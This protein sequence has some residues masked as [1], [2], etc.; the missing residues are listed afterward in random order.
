MAPDPSPMVGVKS[1]LVDSVIPVLFPAVTGPSLSPTTVTVT[2]VEAAIP[3]VAVVMTIAVADGAAEVPLTDPLINTLGVAEVLKKPGGY[4]KVIL[5]P[6]ASAPPTVVVK[7][8]V[9]DTFVLSATRSDSFI[10]NE[11]NDTRP[12]IPP[13]AVPADGIKSAL[14]DTTTPILL[15]PLA[16]PIVRPESVTVT[17]V[18]A[19]SVPLDTVTTIVVAVDGAAEATADPPL[20]ATG[21]ATTPD[22]KKPDGYVSVMLPPAVNAP[23]AVGVKENVA[24][25]SDFPT[26]RSLGAIKNEAFITW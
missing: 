21:E 23:P 5:L 16:P 12:P 20:N 19:I 9:A 17:G 18:L 1:E 15:P 14:V 10:A 24:D 6:M 11:P 7:L 22:A 25:E 26:T 3:A 13:D 2:F 4:V 8:K